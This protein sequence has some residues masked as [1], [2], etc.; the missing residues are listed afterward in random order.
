[1]QLC[2]IKGGIWLSESKFEHEHEH[3][4]EH[5]WR[6][7][8]LC[9][10]DRLCC[11]SREPRRVGRADIQWSGP[12][13]HLSYRA[14]YRARARNPLRGKHAVGWSPGLQLCEIKGGIWLLESK[15]E[16]E[17]DNEHD[18]R[19][20]SLC[21][22]DRLCCASREPRQVGRADIQWSGPRHHLSYRA[23]Y[24]ARARA[25]IPLR[26]KDAVGWSPGLQLCEIKGGI[27]LSESKFE[28]EHEHDNEHDWRRLSLCFIDR[29]CCASREPRQVGWADIQWSGPHHHLS[30]R[31]RY[32][33]RARILPSA[34]RTTAGWSPGLQL[35]EVKDQRKQFGCED[36]LEYE[37]E[38]DNEHDWRRLSLCFI[39]R[40]CCA[41]REPRQVGRADIQWSGP[42]HHLSDRARYRA[43]ARARIPLRGKDAVGWSP[44]LQLCEIKGGIWLLESKFEHEHD[45]EHDWR[46]L[47]LCF[48]DRLCCASREPRQVGRA[49]IQW[50]GAH[51]HLSNRARYR[52]RARARAR[53]PLRGKDAVGWSPG[54]QLCEIKGGIWLLESKFEHEHDNEHDWRRLSL[55]FI[56]RLCCA[57]REPRQVGRADIQWSGAHHH[58]SYRARARIP[59]RGKHAVG[60]SPGLQLCEIKGGIWLLESKFEHEHEHDNEHDWRRPLHHLEALASEF[61]DDRSQQLSVGSCWLAVGLEMSMVPLELSTVPTEN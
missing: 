52:A 13:H 31:A 38:H 5:D 20:L 51:H 14:P 9:F 37:H 57:S 45:N 36:Q 43:R 60:W 35:C 48:I 58:L 49:D 23:R 29:L 18:W 19:R 53:I 7:L 32:R 10:I 39:D 28:H 30:D 54:L 22:I 2:E 3:D 16:H 15:F 25:R 8:S 11:A 34:G 21:F 4:N 24:R 26:G 47:S 12:H 46:R 6:R 27:W 33:A 50:S 41:S 40:L 1:M 56:D 59:L 17:H 55:C 42:H 44:G 61:T